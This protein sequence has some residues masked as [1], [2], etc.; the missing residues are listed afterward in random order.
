M[1]YI[2]DNKKEHQG[3]KKH[4]QMHTKFCLNFRAFEPRSTHQQQRIYK[5]LISC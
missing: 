2:F 5:Q 1:E 3:E 4:R